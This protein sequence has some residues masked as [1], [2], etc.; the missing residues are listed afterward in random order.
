[1][2]TLPFKL[3]VA[4]LVLALVVPA[5]AQRQG[6]GRGGF[7]GPQIGPVLLLNKSVQDELKLTDDQKAAV[8]KIQTKQREALTKAREDAAG[9]FAK[10]REAMQA[11]QQETNKDIA[12]VVDTLTPTQQK[13]FKQIQVQVGGMRALQSPEL[14]KA[15]NLTDKQKEE[16]KGVIEDS[17]KDAAEIF[18]DAQGDRE[19]MQAAM[20]KVQKLNQEANTKAL[21][22][23]NAEQQ[24]TYK[25]L[26]GDKFDFKPDQFGPG[27]RGGRGKNKNKDK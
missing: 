7:G 12:K 13:R 3:A 17:Q 14:A 11:V 27:G 9:D 26:A 6:R 16:I 18:K 1:M 20:Q 15:L 22:V 25:E 8:T 10:M 2:R 4:A 24:T 23:L 19:K 5:F 21:K